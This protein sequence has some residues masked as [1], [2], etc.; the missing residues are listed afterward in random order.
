M[1]KNFKIEVRNIKDGHIHI[2][3]KSKIKV[4]KIYNLIYKFFN[5]IDSVFSDDINVWNVKKTDLIDL[6]I[7]D[8]EW[9]NLLLKINNSYESNI[10][11]EEDESSKDKSFIEELE[12]D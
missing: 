6:Q 9:K 12:E 10:E 2:Y 3:L 8:L 4:A 11:E 1:R 7:E 5:N